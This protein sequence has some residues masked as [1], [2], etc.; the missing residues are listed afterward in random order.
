MPR[1]EDLAAF[2]EVARSLSFTRA[3]ETLSLSRPAVSK[4]IN[5]LELEVG[6]ALLKRSTRRVELTDAGAALLLH[7]DQAAGEIALGLDAARTAAGSLAGL[8]RISVPPSYGNAIVLPKVRDF[9]GRHP[10]VQVDVELSEHPVDLIAER[11]DFALRITESPPP[12]ASVR[13]IAAI[14]WL[15]VASRRYLQQ[16][17]MPRTPADLRNHQ[18]LL[19]SAYR[20]HGDFMFTNGRTHEAVRINAALSTTWTDSIARLVSADAGIA[21]LPDYLL[22]SGLHSG[23]IDEVLPEWQLERGPAD[24]LVALFLPGGRLRVAARALLDFLTPSAPVGGDGKRPRL[25]R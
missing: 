13:R 3:A 11:L 23:A 17:G 24:E 16:H 18:V 12:Q 20:G 4:R 22:A 25:A 9:L 1:L 6:T 7:V 8:V 19:P 21:L 2:A 15:L 5:A 10:A 14:S